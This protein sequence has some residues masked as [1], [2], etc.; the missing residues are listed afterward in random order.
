MV[1][2]LRFLGL[3]ISVNDHKT[4]LCSARCEP[5]FLFHRVQFLMETQRS[6]TASQFNVSF[7]RYDSY[8]RVTLM[9]V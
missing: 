2:L 6:L 5:Q 4:A 7:K 9:F 3:I 8:R 1:T